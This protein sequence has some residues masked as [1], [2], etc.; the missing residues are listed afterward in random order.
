MDVVQSACTPSQMEWNFQDL[1]I[2]LFSSDLITV[3]QFL[4]VMF[5]AFQ[6]TTDM[7]Y[8]VKVAKCYSGIATCLYVGHVLCKQYV[9]STLPILTLVISLIS[10]TGSTGLNSTSS[11]IHKDQ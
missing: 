8:I 10:T 1:F 7:M 5:G 9:A 6:Y 2:L 3:R 4:C 11:K